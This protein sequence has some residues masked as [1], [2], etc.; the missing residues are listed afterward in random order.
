MKREK[1]KEVKV[2][3]MFFHII[4]KIPKR[5]LVEKD[6]LFFTSFYAHAGINIRRFQSGTLFYKNNINKHKILHFSIRN[7]ILHRHIGN[8]FIGLF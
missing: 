4:K 8:I 2:T 1:T 5:Q 7:M 3:V 6:I